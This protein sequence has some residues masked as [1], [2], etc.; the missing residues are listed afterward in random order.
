MLCYLRRFH[1]MITPDDLVFSRGLRGF[2]S[3][4]RCPLTVIAGLILALPLSAATGLPVAAPD[5]VTGFSAQ[6]L[7]RVG[8]YL[9]RTVDAHQYAGATWLVARDGKIVAQGA[10]GFSDV[11]ARA[12]MTENNIFAIASM[13]KLVTV[14]TALTL[15]EEGR[16]HLDEPV[17]T[18]LPELAN[19][20]VLTGGTADAPQLAPLARPV[21]IRHLLTH[22]AGFTYGLFEP[23]PF[24]G[25]Y[26]A[27]KLDES[28]SL[29]DHVV[30]AAKL[31]LK[32][33]PG[34]AFN[35]GI[36]I[37]LIG[38]LVE[39]ITGQPLET[40]MRE[41]IFVPLGMKDTGFSPADPARLAKYYAR[42]GKG[43]F[44]ARTRPVVPRAGTFVN[45]GG[46]LFS[47]LPD[48]ARF[49]QMLL[50]RGELD[51]VRVLGRKTVE[52]MTSNQVEYL[53]PRPKDRWVPPGF[54]FGVRVRRDDRGEFETL[55]SPGQFGWEGLTTTYVSIDPH[56]RMFVLLLTQHAP[57]D[58]DFIF[59]KFTNTVYQA[60]DK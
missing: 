60:L 7:L 10:V 18:Y 57:Y 56:E 55:G 49:A 32:F 44:E 35:Y 37:D 15:L 6:R 22:T 30:R 14:V 11:A 21:T 4:V 48:Y 28:T 16:F 2:R 54:G 3:L 42:D 45:P 43:G 34:D 20:K 5:A 29:A 27:A 52:L 46:G 13:T 58:E 59:E 50:N 24:R 33:Q 40:V 53:N 9:Q 19:L 41:R 12:P 39:K 25:I 38:A 17:A 26:A 47:T 36:S 23:E 51:G 8:A 31:P 1:P